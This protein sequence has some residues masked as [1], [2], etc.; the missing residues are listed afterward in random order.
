MK[1]ADYIIEYLEGKPQG[2]AGGDIERDV[3]DIS[4]HKPS[5]VSRELRNMYNPKKLLQRRYTQRSPHFVIY[6]LI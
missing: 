2:S 5:T 1:C 3:S 6:R 4:G